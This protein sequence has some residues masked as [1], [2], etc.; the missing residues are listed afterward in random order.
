MNYINLNSNRGI[1]NL[2]SDF[3][4]L[5]INENEK[6]DT[7]IEVSDFGRFFVIN[8]LTSR[9]DVVNLS[10]ITDKFK[11]EYGDIL[12]S[13]GYNEINVI[14]L[15]VYGNE[16]HKKNEFWFTFHNTKRPSYSE[17]TIELSSSGLKYHKISDD[18]IELDFSEENTD[19]LGIFTYTPLNI[20]SEFPHGYSLNMGRKFYYYSE[21]ICYHLFRVLMCDKISFKC[22]INK[23]SNDDYDI[24][25]IS[26]SV[27]NN[28]KIKSLVLD[29]FDLDRFTIKVSDYNY[30]ED[31]TKPLGDKPWLI[32]DELKNM[33][34]F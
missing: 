13:I 9:K 18:S 20:S 22:S 8:G 12:T 16:L 14:D 4:L 11:K 30:I 32:N 1:V 31:I 10:D 17:K 25:I 7:L 19:G 34:I 27:Y 5:E 23:N 28:E 2:L 29:V 33:L 15:I 26:N 24:D 3:I 21:Y 6:Y